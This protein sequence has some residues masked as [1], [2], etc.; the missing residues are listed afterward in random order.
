[1]KKRFFAFIFMCVTIPAYCSQAN[2][3]EKTE[4][5]VTLPSAQVLAARLATVVPK[6][7]LKD[8]KPHITLGEQEWTGP[9]VANVVLAELE[10]FLRVFNNNQMLAERMESRRPAIIKC[11]LQESPEAIKDY[12]EF[13]KAQIATEIAMSASKDEKKSAL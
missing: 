9:Q 7:Y 6:Q 3:K 2:T 11:I 1:M 12:E 13:E 8:F 5:R 4:T 10:S